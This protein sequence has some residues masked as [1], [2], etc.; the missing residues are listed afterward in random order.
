MKNGRRQRKT[1]S[2]RRD[3]VVQAAIV[4]FATYGYHGGSTERIASASG[5]SQPYVLQL[6]KTKKA[7]FISALDRVCH[8]IVD[9]WAEA[10]DRFIAGNSGST[11]TPAQRLASLREPFQRFVVDVTGLRLILQASAASDDAEIRARLKMGMADMFGWVRNATGASYEEVQMFWAH[12]MMLMIAASIGAMDD[13]GQSE[14]ARA[15]LMMPD[16]RPEGVLAA[17]DP[18]AES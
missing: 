11:T 4:E 14:W 7:L 2:E 10:L 16:L 13:A 12:G 8:D 18:D 17:T 9:R 5:I 6:F 3:D 15:M 1:A